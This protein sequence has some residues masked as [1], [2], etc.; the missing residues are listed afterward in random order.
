[1]GHYTRLVQSGLPVEQH[2]VSVDEV[3][4]DKLGSPA[5][6]AV[7]GPVG[8]GGRGEEGLGEGLA[9]GGVGGV[10][11]FAVPILVLHEDGAC[12]QKRDYGVFGIP[13]QGDPSPRGLGWV[14]LDLGCST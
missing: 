10:D 4:V 8:V 14:D 1:M 7:S 13:L 5:V 9:L 2:G 11:D 3:A 6:S 12:G